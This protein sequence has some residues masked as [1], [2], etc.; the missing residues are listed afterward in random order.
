MTLWTELCQEF[1]ITLPGNVAIRVHRLDGATPINGRPRRRTWQVLHY[2]TRWHCH[3]TLCSICRH[4]DGFPG[5]P[6]VRQTVLV[7][8]LGP[9]R[10]YTTTHP[11]CEMS[12]QAG[13]RSA[14]CLFRPTCRPPTAHESK[15]PGRSTPAPSR[16][17]IHS[18]LHSRPTLAGVNDGLSLFRSPLH[19]HQHPFSSI[20]LL[21][22]VVQSYPVLSC[23]VLSCPIPILSF[24]LCPFLCLSS[25][26]LLPPLRNRLHRYLL[27]YLSSLSLTIPFSLSVQISTKPDLVPRSPINPVEQRGKGILPPY[28]FLP[29]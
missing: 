29:N 6:T 10:H 21:V 14:L 13:R 15:T 12:G 25:L 4:P 20:S 5:I 9:T 2:R 22:I 17:P 24:C 8:S 28:P 18:S 11:A 27:L 23:S 26:R 3:S 16:L 1:L 7:P 19:T